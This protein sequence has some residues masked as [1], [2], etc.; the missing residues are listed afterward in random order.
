MQSY[1]G[2]RVQYIHGAPCYER[3]DGKGWERIWF[4]EFGN[5]ADVLALNRAEKKDDLEGREEAYTQEVKQ[6]YVPIFTRGGL[7]V[8][9]MPSVPPLREWCAFDF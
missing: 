2:R 8:G 9:G 6:A 4:P 3:P 5:G 1:A 7:G